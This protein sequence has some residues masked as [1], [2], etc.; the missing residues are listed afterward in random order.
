ML[1]HLIKGGVPGVA[2]HGLQV[3]EVLKKK[4]E[5]MFKMPV[6]ECY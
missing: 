2:W 4:L 5:S 1:V 6:K 3:P